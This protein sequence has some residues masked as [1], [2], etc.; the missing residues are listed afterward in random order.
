M[1]LPN[2][3]PHQTIGIQMS[4]A[5]TQPDAAVYRRASDHIQ[6]VASLP[7]SSFIDLTSTQAPVL[8][9]PLAVY[10]LGF[11]ALT[12]DVSLA[13]AR[14]VGWSFLVEQGDRVVARAV[15]HEPAGGVSLS[16]TSRRYPVSLAKAIAKFEHSPTAAVGSFEARILQIN[17]LHLMCLW[18]KGGTG[19]VIPLRPAPDYLHVS[20]EYGEREFF[21]TIHAAEPKPFSYRTLL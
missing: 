21:D 2:D 7:D 19:V 12:A 9:T 16:L 8:A 6:E 10:A 11:D 20:E 4:I 17:A 15:V 5:S 14:F 1:T 18:L 3:A 13:D